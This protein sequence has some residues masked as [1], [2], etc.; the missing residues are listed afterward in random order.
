MAPP[1]AMSAVKKT[2]RDDPPFLGSTFKMNVSPGSGCPGQPR[3]TRRSPSF[4][5][6]IS[7]VGVVAF[8]VCDCGVD[9]FVA[10]PQTRPAQTTTAQA[11]NMIGAARIDFS[12]KFEFVVRVAAE[13]KSTS[14]CGSITSSG[15]KGASLPHRSR[16]LAEVVQLY[17][18][19]FA[20]ARSPARAALLGRQR[21]SGL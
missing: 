19:L 7:G 3:T 6:M 4:F 18:A 13:A 20:I 10:Q 14:R 17:D 16:K 1:G 2:R 15:V 21:E 9:G 5:S 11:L 12:S 8:A